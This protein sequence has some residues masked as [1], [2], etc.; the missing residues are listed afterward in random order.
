MSSCATLGQLL[1]KKSS[2]NEKAKCEVPLR[3][4]CNGKTGRACS[5]LTNCLLMVEL[6][7]GAAAS[8]EETTALNVKACDLDDGSGCFNAGKALEEGY[9]APADP[10][11]GAELM[12]KAFKLLQSECDFGVGDSCFQLAMQRDPETRSK[13]LPKDKALAA[14]LYEQACK[15]GVEMA[16]NREAA[17]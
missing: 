9:G 4:A 8:K 12:A 3:K 2:P 11:K 16:C 15:G 13:H 10:T 1:L 17:K 6:S 7:G 5:L 14:T